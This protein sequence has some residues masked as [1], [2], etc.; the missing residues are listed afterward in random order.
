MIC[1]GY[2]KAH[3]I[4]NKLGLSVKFIFIEET[5]ADC[6]E[7]INLLKN[8]DATLVF[9]YYVCGDDEIL[10]YIA[11]QNMKSGIFQNATNVN[12]INITVNCA[13]FDMLLKIPFSILF[14]FV[15]LLCIRDS[16]NL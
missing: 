14:I 7:A 11:Q 4:I 5:R 3:L 8:L 15:V 10:S 12:N 1:L 16:L 13:I 9:A 2:A 6:K